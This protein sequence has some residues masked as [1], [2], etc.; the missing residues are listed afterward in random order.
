MTT[1]MWELISSSLTL[2]HFKLG[3]GL[4]EIFASFKLLTSSVPFPP[5]SLPVGSQAAFDD[6]SPGQGFDQTR[7]AAKRRILQSSH[8]SL[9]SYL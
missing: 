1:S 9:N 3:A 4:S 8:Y 5:S 2:Q 6:G 7:P